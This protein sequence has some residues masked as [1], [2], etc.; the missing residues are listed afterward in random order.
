MRDKP[1]KLSGAD[2]IRFYGLLARYIYLNVRYAY[3]NIKYYI[4]RAAGAAPIEAVKMESC[5]KSLSKEDR[6][7]FATCFAV[8]I[9]MSALVVFIR[10]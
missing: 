2:V 4:L 10:T 8:A 6:V 3:L 9:Y 7:I 1:E 5:L